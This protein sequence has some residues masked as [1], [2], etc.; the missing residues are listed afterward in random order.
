MARLGI[1][2]VILEFICIRFSVVTVSL[3]SDYYVLALRRGS[4]RQELHDGINEH[5][6]S[7]TGRETSVSLN[8]KCPCTTTTNL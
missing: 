3:Y 7:E 1:T 6:G 5:H 8:Q 4:A 2:M